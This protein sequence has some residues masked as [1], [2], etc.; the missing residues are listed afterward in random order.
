MKQYLNSC[1]LYILL[2][3]LY[4]LQGTLYASGSAISQGILAVL[5]VWSIFIAIKVNIEYKMPAFLKVLNIFIVVMT[6]YGIVLMIG[7]EPL[8]LENVLMEKVSKSN[9]L[10]SIYMSL[11]PIYVMFYYSDKGSLSQNVIRL[12]S[13]IWLVI[14]ILLFVRGQREAELLALH[15]GKTGDVEIT[16][17]AAYDLLYLFPLI[18]FWR[19]TPLLQ[20]IVAFVIFAFIVAGMK[21]GAILIGV[22]CL[23]WFIYQTIQ[24]TRGFR[25]ISI[26]ILTFFLIYIGVNYIENL[27]ETSPYFKHRIE[28]TLEGNT[29]GRDF[30][31]LSLWNHFQND[32]SLIHFLF[33]NG[34]SATI[35]VFGQ[36]AH[37]DWLELLIN[38]GLLGAS[39]YAFCFITLLYT[40]YI[41]R[42]N[43][44][45]FSLL[46]MIFVIMFAS[47]LFSMSY[48]SLGLPI[49][50]G[51]GYCLC[52]INKIRNININDC[53]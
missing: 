44:E 19:K 6:T 7:N 24:N 45:V 23:L 32:M 47:S 43:E 29:S 33:G 52:Y 2:W 5:M 1:T 42:M 31:Y 40:I 3:A 9:F 13:L 10:K 46:V 48:S 38:Q 11:L 4:Y 15:L 53:I 51:L 12:F 49:A 26:I 34:A 28:Q 16:N 30:I 14:V 50:I 41:S 8:Y 37:N 25:K 27:Y 18:L 36:Y 17:N 22:V 20:Y 39:I 21:R 35:K